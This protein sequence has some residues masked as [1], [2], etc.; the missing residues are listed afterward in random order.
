MVPFKIILI[1]NLYNILYL[2]KSVFQNY[3]I[4]IQF[5][6]FIFNYDIKGKNVKTEIKNLNMYQKKWLPNTS[7]FTI[8]PFY[9][10]YDFLYNY[11]ADFNF[12]HIFCYK[13][14]Y[15]F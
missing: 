14:N 15:F 1:Y 3:V 11:G 7:S 12:H 2:L 6:D 10:E 13:K 9:F 5:D 4:K 8:A